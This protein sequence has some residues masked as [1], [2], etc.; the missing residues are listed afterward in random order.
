MARSKSSTRTAKAT[1]WLDWD[2]LGGVQ[3]YGECTVFSPPFAIEAGDTPLCVALVRVRVPE[4][5]G[6]HPEQ[7]ALQLPPPQRARVE[8]A[9]APGERMTIKVNA[10]A[11]LRML[12][13]NVVEMVI[14]GERSAEEG[15]AYDRRV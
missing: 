1:F 12:P 2:D 11:H 4:E 15:P 5:G 3:F 9:M 14:M 10:A 8:V 7:I 13:G 6:L